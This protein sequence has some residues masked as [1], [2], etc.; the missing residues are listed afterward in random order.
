MKKYKH[1]R[2]NSIKLMLKDIFNTQV[3]KGSKLKFMLERLTYYSFAIARKYN[4]MK[5]NKKCFG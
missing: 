1:S 2:I 5:K 4:L 3:V